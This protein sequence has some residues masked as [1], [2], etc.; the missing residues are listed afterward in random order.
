MQ[1]AEG[2]TVPGKE[3]AQVSGTAP[4]VSR[5]QRERRAR[6]GAAAQIEAEQGQEPTAGS[7]RCA[8]AS[9]SSSCLTFGL[10]RVR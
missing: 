3:A 8:P 9:G 2:D 5:E 10:F 6:A 4:P 7:L 1:P